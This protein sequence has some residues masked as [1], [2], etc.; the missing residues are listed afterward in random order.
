V[1]GDGVQL[2]GEIHVLDVA[3][4]RNLNLNRGEIQNT[5]DAS[6]DQLV[7]YTLSGACGGGDDADV[8]I[9]LFDDFLQFIHVVDDEAVGEAL[10]DLLG[11][12]IE[13]RGE[14][15]AVL[16]EIAVPNEGGAQISQSD[17]G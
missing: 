2:D 4:V 13:S 17:H 8:H 12:R 14:N 15:V 11:V 16:Y 9:A 10:A 1:V 7:G 3:A 5:V 6:Q